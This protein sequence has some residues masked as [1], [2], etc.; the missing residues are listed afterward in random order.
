MVLF[1][2]SAGFDC[3]AGIPA[4]IVGTVGTCG[5]NTTDSSPDVLWRSDDAAGSALAD[6]SITVPSSRTSAVFR[7]PAGAAVLYARLYWAAQV[8]LAA[9]PNPTVTFE[10]PGG[11]SRTVTA[12]K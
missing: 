3:R 12:D 8:D 10:R 11:F 1:G 2:N 4:P 5:A 9:T 6:T 7:L